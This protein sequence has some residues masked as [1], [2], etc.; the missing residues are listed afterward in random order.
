MSYEENLLQDIFEELHSKL[1]GLPLKRVRTEA[2]AI[3]EEHFWDLDEVLELF[4]DR[5]GVCRRCGAARELCDM[6]EAEDEAGPCCLCERC[7]GGE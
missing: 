4:L 6:M 2:R 7:S 1:D 3:L 5:L